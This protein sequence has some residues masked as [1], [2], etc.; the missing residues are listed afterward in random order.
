MRV[1]TVSDAL[2]S[3][4]VID[5]CTVVLGMEVPLFLLDSCRD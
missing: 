1:T 4:Q 5:L 2:P 3:L